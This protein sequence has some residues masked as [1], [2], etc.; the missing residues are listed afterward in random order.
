M[1]E[2]INTYIAFLIGLCTFI[3]PIILSVLYLFKKASE[4]QKEKSESERNSALDAA[5][6]EAQ[7]PGTTADQKRKT[8]FVAVKKA[9][10]IKSRSDKDTRLLNPLRQLIRIYLPLILAIAIAL[11]NCLVREGR[12]DLYSHELSIINLSISFSFFAYCMFAII[13]VLFLIWK[14]VI[15][16]IETR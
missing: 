12:W 1:Q 3:A 7:K 6:Q 15:E 11:F 13:Q 2:V 5:T 9:D 10:N 14:I 16:N 4:H 8:L